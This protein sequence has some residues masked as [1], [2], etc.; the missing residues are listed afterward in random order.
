MSDYTKITEKLNRVFSKYIR[1]RDANQWGNIVCPIC[2]VIDYRWQDMQCLHYNK[3]DH[4]I[5]AWDEFNAIG[6]CAI[7]NQKMEHNDE[8]KDR[9]TQVIRDRFGAG[10]LNRL[11]TLNGQTIK[12]MR[13]DLLFLIQ[14]Y[15]QKIKDL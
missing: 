14:Y 11:H 13:N 1:M 3:R 6:G 10:N 8:V 9:F 7:C 2:A 15:Q 4:H 5:T 12:Y